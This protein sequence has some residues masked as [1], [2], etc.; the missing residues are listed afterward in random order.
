MSSW[1]YQ[2]YTMLLCIELLG[3]EVRYASDIHEAQEKISEMHEAE[4]EHVRAEEQ[5]RF[6]RE[7]LEMIETF[8]VCDPTRVV[9]LLPSGLTIVNRLN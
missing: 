2:E 6:E 3:G 8:Q 1:F 4:D 5:R 7:K 9:F